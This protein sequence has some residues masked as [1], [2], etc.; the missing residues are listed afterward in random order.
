MA[1]PGTVSGGPANPPYLLTGSTA[2]QLKIGPGAFVG[3]VNNSTSAQTATVLL[4]DSAST[5]NLGAPIAS[6]ATLGATQVITWPP[7]GR[8]FFNG[9]VAQASSTPLATG[10]EIYFA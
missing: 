8:P 2:V 5:T 1:A 9:L 3:V 6:V 4:Y 7:G 10:I